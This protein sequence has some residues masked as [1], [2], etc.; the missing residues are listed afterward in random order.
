M[1]GMALRTL[2][3]AVVLGRVKG[4]MGTVT[5]QWGHLATKSSPCKW[6][7]DILRFFLSSPSFL[8]LLLPF[9]LLE[10]HAVLLALF[11]T[12]EENTGMKIRCSK[13]IWI[14]STENL[15]L[16][17]E[18]V[19]VVQRL[20]T[21]RRVMTQVFLFLGASPSGCKEIQGRWGTGYFWDVSQV[22]S[23]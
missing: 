21:V 9:L 15:G 16:L 18:K 4:R 20:A 22:S 14:N 17:R 2:W 10:P 23:T 12:R 19:A 13:V 6:S 5:T 11:L 1:F 8:S 7:W 3:F